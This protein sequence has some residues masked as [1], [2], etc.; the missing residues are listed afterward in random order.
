MND[1]TPESTIHPA[2][3]TVMR[4]TIDAALAEVRVSFGPRPS[5]SVP[6]AWA[7][8]MLTELATKQPNVFGKLL[9]AA[10]LGTE[11]GQ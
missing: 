3:T 6:L 11:G 10:A 8:S 1:K 7:E 9:Q 2:P 4:E 5:Q